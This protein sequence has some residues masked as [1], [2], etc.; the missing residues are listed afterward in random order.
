MFPEGVPGVTQGVPQE[1]TKRPSGE[2]ANEGAA[3]EGEPS[4]EPKTANPPERK[5]RPARK[6]PPTQSAEAPKKPRR[7]DSGSGPAGPADPV[8]RRHAVVAAN[9]AVA[10]SLAGGAAGRNVLPLSKAVY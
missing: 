5:E 10:S 7:G 3:K 2:G 4:A 8:A 9:L 1:Y 6:P